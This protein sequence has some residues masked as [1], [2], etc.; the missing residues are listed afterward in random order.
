MMLSE[1]S[2][3]GSYR[4]SLSQTTPQL[5]EELRVEI[6]RLLKCIHPKLNITEEGLIETQAGCRQG[7]TYSGQRG[8]FAVLDR[9]EYINKAMDL[10][11]D[12]GTYSPLTSDTT[13]KHKNTNQHVQDYKSTGS[14]RGHHIEIVYPTG[15][16]SPKIYGLSKIDKNDISLR[17]IVSSRGVVTYGV[18]KE[19]FNI[20][21]PLVGHSPHY[22]KN[23]QDFV[24]QVKSI[25][26]WEEECI[27]SYDIKALFTSVPVD[28]AIP[29]M[30]HKLE[31]DMQLHLGTS[32]VIQY[33][34][35]LLEFYLQN[36]YFLFQIKYYEKVQG[37]TMGSPFSPIV[38]NLFME[39]FE[40]KTINSASPS[41]TVWIMY[42]DDTFVIC[43]ALTR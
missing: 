9:Q 34:I 12:R 13:N 22:I 10:L 25:R 37:A 5:T 16:A 41:T 19:L 15:V 3:C 28:P 6:D 32:M 21:R 2:I 31:Q 42:M 35:T 43:N 29:I 7:H 20:I 39:E 38:A 36:T 40:I 30:R 18:A 1:R 4:G 17:P 26:I 33:I 23:I 24:D 14:T 11:A 27:T 8:G